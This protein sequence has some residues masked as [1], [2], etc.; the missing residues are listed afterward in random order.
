MVEG[1]QV[2]PRILDEHPQA[3]WSSLGWLSRASSTTQCAPLLLSWVRASFW[4]AWLDPGGLYPEGQLQATCPQSVCSC[5]GATFEAVCSAS[6]RTFCSTSAWGFVRGMGWQGRRMVS[7][8]IHRA[9]QT[10]WLR[11]KPGFRTQAPWT[12]EFHVP[13]PGVA[14]SLSSSPLLFPSSLKNRLCQLQQTAFKNIL[15]DYT[16]LL[17]KF[18]TMPVSVPHRR[19][20]GVAY[21][22]FSPPSCFPA[23]NTQVWV[24]G[25]PTPTA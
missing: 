13:V 1:T 12:A 14:G 8:P 22:I 24:G 2:S 18:L 9:A 4:P 25:P 5:T 16:A 20:T 19:N 15:L 17:S 10:L 11:G 7:C 3:R 21:L 6:F 23:I